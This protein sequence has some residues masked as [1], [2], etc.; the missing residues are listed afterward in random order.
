MNLAVDLPQKVEDWNYETI[1]DVVKKYEYEPALFDY[2]EVLNATHTEKNEHNTNI[3]K[4]ACT[5]ANADG[6]FILFGILDRNKAVKEPENRIVG[7][8]IE[9][10]LRK[11]FAEKLSQ[12]Q[13]SIYF[14]AS[15]KTIALPNNPKRGIFV[16]YIP[17]SPFR[18]HMDESTGI[19]Y[20]RGHGGNA[21]KM[22]Y[23]E[24]QE[25]MLYT[26]EKLRKLRLFRFELAQYKK[27]AIQ[28]LN[29]KEKVLDTLLRFDTASFKIMLTDICSL[30]PNSSNLLELLLNVPTITTI[31]NQQIQGNQFPSMSYNQS[32][33]ERAKPILSNLTVL[34]GNITEH[35]KQIEE[36]FGKMNK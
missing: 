8:P 28:M 7:L 18:P 17:R 32:V 20:R 10:D 22:K 30:I 11:E 14:E 19:F 16:V 3:R 34:I 5:L 15:P 31:I 29:A 23:Y 26:E 35:E 4:T 9:G 36:I 12:I 27:I 25:Q 6:G 21:E 2:K 24:V 1:L 33:T 13:R